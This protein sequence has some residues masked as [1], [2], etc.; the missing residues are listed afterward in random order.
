VLYGGIKILNGDTLPLLRFISYTMFIGMLFNPCAKLQIIQRNATGH[1][2][3]KP[4][5]DILDTE[6]Q[7]QDTGIIEAPIFKGDIRFEKV[8]FG[9]S[10]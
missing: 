8:R 5:F 4:R 3:S 9:Y 1:D 10:G 7:I 2:C 6:D